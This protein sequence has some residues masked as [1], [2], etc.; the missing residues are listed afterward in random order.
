MNLILVQIVNITPNLNEAETEV[1]QFSQK[2]VIVEK[3]L[4]DKKI[5]TSLRS[6]TS[7]DALC[8]LCLIIQ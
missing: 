8:S 1:Y 4:Y 6:K 7:K 5:K 2:E 3:L